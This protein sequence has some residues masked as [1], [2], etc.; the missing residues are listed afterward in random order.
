MAVPNIFGTATAAIPLSQLDQNFATAITLGNT[1]VYLGNTTTSLGNVTLTNVTISSGNVTL[2]GANV[3]GTANVSTLVVTGNAVVSVT[4]NTNAALRITQLGTGNALLVE[5]STNPDSTPFVIDAS[6]NTLV[7]SLV[8]YATVDSS[9]TARTPLLQDHGLSQSTAH[10]AVFNWSSSTGSAAYLSLN[11]SKSNAIGT[12]TAVSLNDD[13]GAINFAA[14]DGTAFVTAAN[15]LAEVDGT[16]GTNDMPGRL[17]FST[18]ADGASSPTERMRIAST[19][20][21]TFTTADMTVANPSATTFNTTFKAAQT[22]TSIGVISTYN[23]DATYT[24]AGGIIGFYANQGTFTVAPAIQYGF[25]YPSGNTGGVINY[26]FYSNMASGTGRYNLYMNGNAVNYLAGNLGIATLAP[27]CALDVTGGIQTSRTAVTA[28]AA[29]D[30]NVFSGTYT[31]TLTNTTN[32]AASTAYECQ[33]MRVGNTVT[34]SGQVDIDPTLAATD[35]VLGMTLPIASALAA[36]R[37]LGGTAANS[38]A[39][40]YG[41]GVAITADLTNDRAQFLLRPTSINNSS[42]GFSFTYRVL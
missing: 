13:I 11:K 34:V 1:A 16:P 21:F 35:T 24:G 23:T 5:D 8:A 12:Q 40:R 18:T 25:A 10:T 30:G 20:Q 4:D 28:P 15:I 9:N 19:G 37:Q 22:G 36:N 3:S 26:A 38:T 7:G 31:P 32:V 17:V 27:A 33:Y 29:T 6:G 2:T 14:S 41:E 39:G 42:Y